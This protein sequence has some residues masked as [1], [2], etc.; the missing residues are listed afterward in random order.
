MA[1]HT[2]HNMAP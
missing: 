2:H 1:V